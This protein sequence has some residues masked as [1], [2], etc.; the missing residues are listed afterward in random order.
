MVTK[1]L[2]ASADA[3]DIEILGDDRMAFNVFDIE[4]GRYIRISK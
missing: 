4:F 1:D 3:G 2:L